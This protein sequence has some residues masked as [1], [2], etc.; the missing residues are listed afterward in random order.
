MGTGLGL[1]RSLSKLAKPR[2]RRVS[3][4]STTTRYQENALMS[5]FPLL[6]FVIRRAE[7]KKQ[8]PWAWKDES[9]TQLQTPGPHLEAQYHSKS[10]TLFSVLCGHQNHCRHSLIHLILF[11]Y[12]IR[13]FLLVIYYAFV[14]VF[15]YRCVFIDLNILNGNIEH[16][17][18]SILASYDCFVCL[19]PL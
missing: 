8:N 7:P 4:A 16:L 15:V 13:C 9:Q 3:L 17:E 11:I 1:I 14:L 19:F 12:C 18:R 5:V 2:W 10:K 6:W